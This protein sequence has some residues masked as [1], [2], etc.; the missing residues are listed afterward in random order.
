M[1]QSPSQICI[2]GGGFGGL[3]TALYLSRYRWQTRPQITLVERRDHFLFTPL[4]Y[5]LVT[6]ELQTWQIAPRF[7]K[8]LA[9]TDIHYEQG[10]VESVD[11][12]MRQVMLSGGK[13]LSYDR[14]VIGIGKETLL[15]VV[16]GAAGNALP[17]RSLADVNRLKEQLRLLESSDLSQIRVAVVGAGP[18]GVEL[19]C[20]IA[21]RLKERGRLLLINRGDKILKYFADSSR[22]AALKA[23]KRRGVQL[24]LSTTV[25]SV[26]PNFITLVHQ[27]Q[28]RTYPVDLVLWTIGT[29]VGDWVPNITNVQNKQG[30]LLVLPTLQL[31]E[32]P[33]VFA[34]GDIAAS[35]DSEH[36]A[37]ATAQAAFQQAKIA[38]RNIRSSL[39][40]RT[41][42]AFRY[43][44][45]GE[46]ITLGINASAVSSFGINLSGP[47][48]GVIR[49]WVYLLRMP[50]FR[51]RFQVA[52]D[53][54]SRLFWGVIK[55]LVNAR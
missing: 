44:H 45:I 32:H 20:K 18:N 23:L 13:V 7:A 41:L 4:L 16:P 11:L 3:Y 29:R 38:A 30:E 34:L 55:K 54:L 42:L 10:T 19:A 17:F 6:G 51:H 22:K 14:L 31:I 2:L 27:D 15:D 21:D 40:G 47:V 24:E 53:W 36:W 43:W 28:Q 50:T 25:E 52:R 46:M 37:P 12:D 49:Q 39:T 33:E 9:G 5:E 48:A 26:E 8:L 1:S 35:N